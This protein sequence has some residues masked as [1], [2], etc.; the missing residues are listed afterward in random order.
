[1]SKRSLTWLRQ[2]TNVEDLLD[3][4]IENNSDL[5]SFAESNE[6]TDPVSTGA[7]ASDASDQ[8]QPSVIRPDPLASTPVSYIGVLLG[9]ALIVGGALL[10]LFPVDMFV[11]HHRVMYLPSVM[12]HVTRG[13]SE[14]YGAAGFLLGFVVLAYAA[15]KPRR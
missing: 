1:M 4:G 14:F 3:D 8:H 2:H 11:Y 5:K 9:S 12:E 7:L 13:R 6:S 15:Y 10:F